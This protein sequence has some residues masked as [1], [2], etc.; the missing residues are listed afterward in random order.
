M[1][2]RTPRFQLKRWSIFLLALAVGVVVVWWMERNEVKVIESER[3]LEVRQRVLPR[4]RQEAEAAGLR[5][6]APVL[7]RSFKESR[8]F[9]VWLESTPGGSFAHFKTYRLVNWGPGTLGP[10]LKEGDRQSPEGFYTVGPGQLNPNS[11]YHLSFNTGYPNAFDQS[12]GRTGS[13]I[14]IHGGE[15]SIGCLAV[16]D[17]MIEEIYLLAEAA[18]RQGQPTFAVHLFPFRLTADRLAL[19]SGHPWHEFWQNL[20]EGEALFQSTHRPPAVRA[21]RGRYVFE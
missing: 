11:D 17:E 7:M 10:K 9:E 21:D 3:L 15:G 12:L 6:G 13:F 18:L 16:T 2:S 20:R 19:E 4:L 1:R 14:M 8:E 5:V